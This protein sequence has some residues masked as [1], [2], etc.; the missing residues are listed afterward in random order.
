MKTETLTMKRPKLNG[1]RA[2]RV[3]KQATSALRIENVLVPLD[4]SPASHSAI[5]SAMPFLKRFGASLHL[6]HVLP[7]DSPMSGFPDL[8]MV[9]PDVEIKRRV[10]RDLN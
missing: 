4:F 1:A 10:R 6:V 3:A 5:Q 9:L 7:A 8:P 2:T